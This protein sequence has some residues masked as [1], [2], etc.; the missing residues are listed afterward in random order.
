MTDRLAVYA[1]PW[2]QPDA[3][4]VA[5]QGEWFTDWLQ[6]GLDLHHDMRDFDGYL[7]DKKMYGFWIWEGEITYDDAKDEHSFAGDW[8]R[9]TSEEA[10]RLVEGKSP[11]EGK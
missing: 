3:F 4:I 11:W 9:P 10:A 8:R 5:L 2:D 1:S 7:C 6:V